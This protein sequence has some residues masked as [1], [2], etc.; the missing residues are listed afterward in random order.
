MRS[1]EIEDSRKGE[2]IIKAFKNKKKGSKLG[3]HE[4]LQG[5]LQIVFIKLQKI[6]NGITTHTQLSGKN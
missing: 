6:D 5:T 4:D 1:M 3:S 2:M